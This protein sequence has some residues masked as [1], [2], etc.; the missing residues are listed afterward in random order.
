MLAASFK[1]YDVY[2]QY[3]DEYFDDEVFYEYD[4]FAAYL[5]EK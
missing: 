4:D 5:L 2:A 3:L 1:Y